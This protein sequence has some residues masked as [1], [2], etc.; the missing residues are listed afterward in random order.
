[1]FFAQNCP[2]CSQ[3]WPWKGLLFNGM[4]IIRQ[5]KTTGLM[6]LTRVGTG[7]NAKAERSNFGEAGCLRKRALFEKRLR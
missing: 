7:N 3:K 5:V 1:M 6:G 4:E 2:K